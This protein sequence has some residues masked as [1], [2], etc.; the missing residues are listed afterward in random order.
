MRQD[1]DFLV[2]RLIMALPLEA[3]KSLVRHTVAFDYGSS[4]PPPGPTYKKEAKGIYAVSLSIAGRNGRFMTSAELADVIDCMREYQKGV[5][6]CW[7]TKQKRWKGLGTAAYRL[8]RDHIEAVD[9]CLHGGSTPA[10]GAAPRWVIVPDKAEAMFQHLD[11]LVAGARQLNNPTG[12]LEQAPVMVGCTMRAISQR[13]K[14]HHPGSGTLSGTTSTW[15]LMCCSIASKGLVPE[16][17]SIPLLATVNVDELP[18]AEMLVTTLAQS[19]V[20]QT[21][22]NIVEGGGQKDSTNAIE[23]LDDREYAHGHVPWLR[24]HCIAA[25]KK[26]QVKIDL[27]TDLAK[28]GEITREN[29]A[30]LQDMKDTLVKISALESRLPEFYEQTRLIAEGVAAGREQIKEVEAQTELLK[31][32]KALESAFADALDGGDSEDSDDSE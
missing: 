12:P 8:H 17:V 25:S 23:V 13:V 30:L 3:T 28:I 26:A 29:A 16:A 18:V 5:N 9:A 15:G 10:P 27:M 19:L 4:N 31:D 24:E 22:F 2:T 32:F 20:T 6:T 7:D 21:G 11:K 1:P 14:D